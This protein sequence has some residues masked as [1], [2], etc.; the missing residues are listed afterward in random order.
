M[1][2]EI[3]K[4]EAGAKRA[5]PV[6]MSWVGGISALIG[7]F[8]SIA[9][10]VSWYRTH[11]QHQLERE[12]K[13]TLAQTQS[14]QGEYEA[15][16]Q[17]YSEILKSD[18]LDADALDRQLD[19]AMLWAEDFH[20]S[21][22]EGGNSAEIS[23]PA[24]DQIFSILDSGLARAK[25]TQAADIQ[26]HIGWAHWL[27]QKIA[28]R[29]FGSAAEQALTAALAAD[30]TNVYAN[31]MLGNWM[32]QTGGSLTGAV[33]HF[34]TAVAAGKARPFVRRYQLGALID[35]EKPGARAELIRIANDMRKSAEP[36]GDESRSR[37]DGFC[38]DPIV[39]DHNQLVESLSAVSPD[40]AWK[41]YLWLD[42]RGTDGQAA[43]QP[44][45]SLVHD[46]IQANL[47]EVSG[48][49]Q[50]SLQ[51]FRVLQQKLKQQQ[52]RMKD[53]VDA[54]VARLAHS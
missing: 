5:W 48:K 24:L 50:Q 30:P 1:G 51:A 3:Q 47:L 10:G 41:T 36:L 32:L 13:M 37:I 39:T 35:I 28:Q 40:D 45:P 2:E 52:G 6:V 7:L 19:T 49:R 4:A 29:E 20:V 21:T 26:A 14:G 42:N 15:A 34:N 8:A 12:S 46:F 54:A 25:G 44:D 9:G 18:P 33:Q 17:T 22:P 11:H 53:S 16:L 31:A 23:A 43:Q 27:N 38:F